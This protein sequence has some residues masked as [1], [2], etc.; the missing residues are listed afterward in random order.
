MQNQVSMGKK[1]TFRLDTA[2]VDR[3]ETLAGRERVPLSY[4]LRN[5]VLRFLAPDREC[6]SDAGRTLPAL[7][8]VPG[9]D[10]AAKRQAEFSAE[11]CAL[12]DGFRSQGLDV[13]EAAKRSNFALKA[14]RHPWATYETVADV[15]RKAGRFRKDRK[16]VRH[17][18]S[19]V[20]RLDWLLWHTAQVRKAASVPTALTACF[21][22]GFVRWPGVIGGSGCP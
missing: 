18:L 17:Q 4:V 21:N 15:L 10:L 7:R 22:R 19:A 3:L 12:F 14:K 16:G 20:Y 1:L 9:P 13:R 5:M 11:V 2:L 8:G 6:P